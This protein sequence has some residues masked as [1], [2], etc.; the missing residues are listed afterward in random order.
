MKV[1]KFRCILAILVQPAAIMIQTLANKQN[2]HTKSHSTFH[3]RT[4]QWHQ[5]KQFPAHRSC[6]ALTAQTNP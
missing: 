2:E 1:A 6:F 4:Y 5:N 3:E